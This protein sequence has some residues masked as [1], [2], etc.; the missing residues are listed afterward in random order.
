MLTGAMVGR[1]YRARA[2]V[3]I[4][5]QLACVCQRRGDM[6]NSMGAS[7]FSKVLHITAHAVGDVNTGLREQVI[8]RPTMAKKIAKDILPS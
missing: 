4:I 8:V 3:T 2:L 1:R 5:A 6:H 7:A